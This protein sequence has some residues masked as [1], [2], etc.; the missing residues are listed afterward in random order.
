MTLLFSQDGNKENQLEVP[1]APAQIP[2]TGNNGQA[3]TQVRKK[4]KSKARVQCSH[5][6]WVHDRL[7]NIYIF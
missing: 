1:A 4:A 6:Q 3:V 7:F 5:F 2:L